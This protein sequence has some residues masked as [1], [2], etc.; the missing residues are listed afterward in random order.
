MKGA[1]LYLSIPASI[2]EIN[3]VCM[4]LS[5]SQVVD[6]DGL[7]NLLVNFFSP[8]ICKPLLSLFNRSMSEGFYPNLFKIE[9][10]I[11]VFEAIDRPNSTNFRPISVLS[12]LGKI[13]EK[14]FHKRII[15][16]FHTNNQITEQWFGFQ[17]K[18]S[19]IQVLIKILERV[20]LL[21]DSNIN[22]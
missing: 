3:N 19:T 10:I 5:N 22:V 9:S 4:G 12:S 16:F 17:P 1:F 14:I 7:N 15:S 11:P 20:R 6:T 8:I 2:E 13:F 18:K 21:I